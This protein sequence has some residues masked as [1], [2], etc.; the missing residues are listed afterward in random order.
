MK[1]TKTHQPKRLDKRLAKKLKARIQELDPENKW[2]LDEMSAVGDSV[3]LSLLNK[4]EEIADRL[5][6]DPPPT[7]DQIRRM[8]G[9]KVARAK[10]LPKQTNG[11][12]S[13][14]PSAQVSESGE[15]NAK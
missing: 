5:I 4:D 15:Q 2:G 9:Y 8:A 6:C 13:P 7:A 3:E 1:Q 10:R 14:S 12:G 11:E